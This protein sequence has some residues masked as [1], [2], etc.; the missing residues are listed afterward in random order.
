MKSMNMRCPVCGD[1]YDNHD[2]KK[3]D[4]CASKQAKAAKP[5]PKS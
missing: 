3:S 5:K 2:E 4:R 1:L